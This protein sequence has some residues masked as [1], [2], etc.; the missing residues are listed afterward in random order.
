VAQP[1]K[2]FY[3][4]DYRNLLD[5]LQEYG[6]CPFS[7]I[8]FT[9]VDNVILATFSYIPFEEFEDYE[10]YRP[11]TI[12]ELCIDYLAWTDADYINDEM[13][14][15]FRKTILLAMALLNTKR[16]SGCVVTDFGYAF[17]EKKEEQFGAL[18]IDLPDDTFAIVY[19]GTDTSL[20]GWKE[21]FNL[22]CLASTPGQ[23]RAAVFVHKAIEESPKKMFRMM[24]H[25]KGGN[26]AVFAASMLSDEEASNL[27]NVYSDDGPGLSAEIFESSGHQ[28]IVH[29]I[30]H[31]VP[32]Y[33][34]IGS[35]LHH[36]EISYVID[37]EGYND[38]IN[39]HDPFTWKTEGIS[40]RKV[41]DR[42]PMSKYIELAMNELL[43]KKLKGKEREM[44]VEALFDT[45]LKTGVENAVDVTKDSTFVRKFITTTFSDNQFDKKVLHKAL[46]DAIACF[47][48]HFG[49]YLRFSGEQKKEVQLG[50]KEEAMTLAMLK[51]RGT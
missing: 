41:P 18:R 43:A 19:R 49:D 27:L 38:F 15:W 21:D 47:R 37:A 1:Y 48:D 2:P 13:P 50:K 23:D 6:N 51:K 28:R 35:L 14:A 20:I 40:F 8:P 31:L 46:G 42:T 4:K 22:A 9:D 26:F 36:E 30:I 32:E 44:F 17:S 25:S 7:E 24:G 10:T 12:Q 33:D 39:Q 45:I 16:F 34:V 5:Y 3:F 11:H 29:K